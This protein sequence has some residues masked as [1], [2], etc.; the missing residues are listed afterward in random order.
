MKELH[1]AA[2]GQVSASSADCLALCGDVA[3]YPRW[4]PDVV[5]RVE[6][7]EKPAVFRATLHA[8][9]GPLDHDFQFLVEVSRPEESLVCLTRLPNEP[10][11]PERLTLHW[12]FHPGREGTELSV[13]VNALLDVPR[14]LPL[15]GAPD[16]VARGFL[17]AARRALR[18]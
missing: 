9:L 11:D 1:G 13:E 4:Y 8:H 17:T 2:T 14:L 3:G 7:L 10:T 15:H 5:R 12:R 6:V 16:A 18:T